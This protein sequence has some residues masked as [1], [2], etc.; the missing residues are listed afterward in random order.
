MWITD[1]H[2]R[3]SHKQWV[4]KRGR[5]HMVVSRM[6]V[7]FVDG[8][9]IVIYTNTYRIS[10]NAYSSFWSY[11]ANSSISDDRDLCGYASIFANRMYFGP[12]YKL[13]Q[14]PTLIYNRHF[15]VNVYV[16]WAS[17]ELLPDYGQHKALIL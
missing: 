2:F 16:K 4:E 3:A 13:I 10:I 15:R 7:I 12:D 6:S 9:H 14:L 1:N 8:A 5:M 11:C 17:W